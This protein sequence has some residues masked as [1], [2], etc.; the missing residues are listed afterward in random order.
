MEEVPPAPETELAIGALLL[1]RYRVERQLAEGGMS[2]LYAGVDEQTGQRVAIKVLPHQMRTERLAARFEREVRMAMQVRHPNL[3]VTYGGG[4][5][6]G[7]TPFLVME[8]LEGETLFEVIQREG[9][10]SIERGVPILAAVLDAVEAAHARGIIHRDLKPSNVFMT[11]DGQVK[12]ID[13]GLSKDLGSVSAGTVLTGPGEAL[14]TP[15]YMAP[16]QIL[17]DEVDART[18]IWGAGTLFYEILTG[19]R[20]FPR[21]KGTVQDTFA[22]VLESEPF[23]MRRLIEDW[24]PAA[25]AFVA[26]ALKKKKEER[27]AS[28]AEMRAA[29]LALLDAPYDP[30]PDWEAIEREEAELRAEIEAERAARRARGEPSRSVEDADDERDEDDDGWGDSSGSYRGWDDETLDSDVDTAVDEVPEEVR[31]GVEKSRDR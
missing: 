1:D 6:E 8:L 30:K 23:A 14:G 11:S 13:F 17:A 3:V 29:L 16:E 12:L 5:L 24:K 25:E 7:G 15:S 2:M 22:R 4:V 10:I 21:L 18:D 9:W 26:R 28:V 31:S 19:I 20:A 27:F